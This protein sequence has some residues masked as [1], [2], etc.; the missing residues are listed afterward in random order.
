MKIVYEEDSLHL[1]RM[2]SLDIEKNKCG[3]H[4]IHIGHSK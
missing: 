2:Y 3:I 4:F 1:Y